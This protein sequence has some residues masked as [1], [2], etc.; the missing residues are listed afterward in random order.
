MGSK[1]IT[2]K[3]LGDFGEAA[4]AVW[5]RKNGYQVLASQFRCRYG[6][7]DLIAKEGN[8]LCFIEVKTRTNLSMALPREY[9]GKQK[10]ARLRAAAQYYISLH[11]LDCTM[12][13]DVAEVYVSETGKT[14]IHYIENAFWAE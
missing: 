5:L 13:F 7:V 11:E 6:E 8:T 9:V 12:R 14:S 10:Q 1:A 4:V 3:Q 2:G